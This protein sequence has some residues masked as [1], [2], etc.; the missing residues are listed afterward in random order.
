[1]RSAAETLP[2]HMDRGVVFPLWIVSHFF[3]EDA[4]ALLSD[5]QVVVIAGNPRSVSFLWYQ[6]MPSDCC[7]NI[8]ASAS[9][10]DPARWSRGLEA[11]A[12]A[13]NAPETV[14]VVGWNS[15]PRRLEPPAGPLTRE[16]AGGDTGGAATRKAII[17]MSR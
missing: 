9:L 15:T 17:V 2:S 12:E 5:Y 13:F 7:S 16:N 8:N 14:P 3:P 6:G 11:L 4:M 10:P 1:M